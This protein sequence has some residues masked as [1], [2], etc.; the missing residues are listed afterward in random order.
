MTQ[1]ILWL[2]FGDSFDLL[3]AATATY[4]RQF[5]KLP[6]HVVTN[7]PE[8]ERHDWPDGTTFGWVD[9]PTEQNRAVKVS[10]IEHTPFDLTL[11]L[12]VDAVLQRPG[13]ERFFDDLAEHDLA[14][15]QAEVIRS[16]AHRAKSNFYRTFYLS[17][18]EKTG[19][20]YPLAVLQSSAFLW[21]Q[22]PAAQRFFGKWRELWELGGCRRDMPGFSLAARIPG[23]KI[24]VYQAKQD[25]F[26]ANGKNT[27]RVIQHKAYRGFLADFGLPEYQDWN[28]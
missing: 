6:M 2:A 14:I 25:G 24:K 16:E 5:T 12:D 28:P 21:R 7:L 22:S 9:M 18:M 11:A 23:V 10:L 3:G 1:G 27:T 26:L 20:S 19:E 4:S 17:L 8:S 15:Q 13:I